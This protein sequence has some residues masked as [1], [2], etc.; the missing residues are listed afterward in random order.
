MSC[1]VSLSARNF[2][3]SLRLSGNTGGYVAAFASAI[4]MSLI[5]VIIKYISD[6]Y[7]LALGRKTLFEILVRII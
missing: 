4:V 2:L 6:E 3:G 5:G 1:T 7:A